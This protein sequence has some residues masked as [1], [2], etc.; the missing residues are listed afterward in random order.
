MFSSCVCARARVWAR[1]P[2]AL[3]VRTDY[4]HLAIYMERRDGLRR[5]ARAAEEIFENPEWT[6][7][8][9]YDGTYS[10]HPVLC[11]VVGKLKLGA[12]LSHKQERFAPR[13]VGSVSD[14]F[15]YCCSLFHDYVDYVHK[16]KKIIIVYNK[17][18]STENN[19]LNIS[20]VSLRS[21]QWQRWH[22]FLGCA[23]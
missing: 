2:L 7:S 13:N 16:Q 1:E 10:Q 18:N 3:A 20:T 5:V 19:D 6:Q 14:L 4:T 8:Q 23:N 15:F 11:S 12:L 9:H 22:F 21:S 17:V